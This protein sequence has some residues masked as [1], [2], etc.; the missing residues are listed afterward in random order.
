MSTVKTLTLL[1]ILVSFITANEI[2]VYEV[3]T[4]IKTVFNGADYTG[5]VIKLNGYVL[6]SDSEGLVNIGTK[7]TYLSQHYFNSISVWDVSRAVKKGSYVSFTIQ[8]ED[9]RYVE[10][11]NKKMIQANAIFIK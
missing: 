7:E 5:K 3:E 9:C 1:L 4:F 10:L 11:N 8:F 2:P 6:S